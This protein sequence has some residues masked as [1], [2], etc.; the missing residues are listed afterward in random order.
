[1]DRRVRER[2]SERLAVSARVVQSGK[3]DGQRWAR[4]AYAVH[5][6]KATFF[7]LGTALNTIARIAASANRTAGSV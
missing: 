2:L 6:D 1:M 7:G 5:L 3:A 4:R